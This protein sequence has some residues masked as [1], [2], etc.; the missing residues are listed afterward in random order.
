MRHADVHHVETA[1]RY[2]DDIE[3][4][5]VWDSSFG[6]ALT[7]FFQAASARQSHLDIRNVVEEGGRPVVT[8]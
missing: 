3:E 1:V 6:P 5:R 7:K 2:E 4:L 8:K